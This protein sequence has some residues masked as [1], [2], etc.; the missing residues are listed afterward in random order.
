[1]RGG[2]SLRPKY[3]Y[4]TKANLDKLRA[5]GYGKPMTCLEDGVRQCVQNFLDTE[6]PYM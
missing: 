1:M 4:Y 5:A 6:D 2:E 3:L